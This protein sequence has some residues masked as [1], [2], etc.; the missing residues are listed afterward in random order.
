MSV[1]ELSDAEIERRYNHY[2]EDRVERCRCGSF[3]SKPEPENGQVRYYCRAC[4]RW[5]LEYIQ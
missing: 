2:D 3:V 1:E 4:D 5:Q